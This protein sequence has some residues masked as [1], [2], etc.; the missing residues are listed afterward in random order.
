MKIMCDV[1]KIPCYVEEIVPSGGRARCLPEIRVQR[2]R[3]IGAQD[4]LEG[5]LLRC[6]QLQAR[7]IPS[8]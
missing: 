6:I 1:S 3:P 2:S 4:L 7:K 8:D 5:R